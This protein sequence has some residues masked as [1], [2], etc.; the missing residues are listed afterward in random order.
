MS[1]SVSY[2]RINTNNKQ[3]LE[4]QERAIQQY[5]TD[6]QLEIVEK[7]SDIVRSD[8]KRLQILLDF[9]QQDPSVDKVLFLSPDRISRSVT[10][11]VEVLN[12]LDSLGK[13]VIFVEKSYQELSRN[14]LAR[15]ILTSFGSNKPKSI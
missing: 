2:S 3:L 7:F 1:K 13:Q 12:I 10:R 14:D 5:A 8:G 9:V 4:V 15:I 6:N 11:V